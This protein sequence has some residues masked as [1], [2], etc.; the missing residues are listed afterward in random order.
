MLDPKTPP[1]CKL[2]KPERKKQT[3]EHACDEI[4]QMCQGEI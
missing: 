3:A 2:C 4:V 1:N